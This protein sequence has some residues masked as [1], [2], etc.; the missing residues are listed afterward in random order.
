MLYDKISELSRYLGI[1]QNL[2][3]AIHYINETE[4]SQLE[5][6][7]YDIDGDK[8]RVFVQDNQLIK[9]ESQEF[10]YHHDYMDIQLIDQGYEKISYGQGEMIRSQEFNLQ[11][12]IGFDICS[13]RVDYYLDT[14]NFVAFFPEERH[15][16]N[17]FAGQGPN[18][19]KYVFKVKLTE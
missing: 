7:G 16:P 3:R 1:H 11:N 9:E 17:H 19:R 13:E 14:E 10:E 18:V 8:V 5:F 2:D 6:G 4:L 15:Q 12:D